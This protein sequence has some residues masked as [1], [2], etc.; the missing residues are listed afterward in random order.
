MTHIKISDD[1]THN[2]YPVG[3]LVEIRP[4]IGNGQRFGMVRIHDHAD[5]KPS[6][7]PM[8]ELKRD[9]RHTEAAL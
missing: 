1:V 8:L 4:C 5:A 9:V 2:G 3:T 7:I 6:A